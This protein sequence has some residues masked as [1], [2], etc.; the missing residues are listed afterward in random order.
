M[1]VM[2]VW[3]IMYYVI[4][5]IQSIRDKIESSSHSELATRL[6]YTNRRMVVMMALLNI[7]VGASLVIYIYFVKVKKY[8]DFYD[9]IYDIPLSLQITDFLLSILEIICD[10]IMFTLFIKNFNYFVS[11]K[12]TKLQQMA[13]DMTTFSKVVIALVYT[14]VAFNMLNSASRIVMTPLVKHSFIGNR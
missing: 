8:I 2:L 6:K 5:K 12:R 3:N 9:P 1:A 13:L 11:M 10:V 4:L 7:S 14:L